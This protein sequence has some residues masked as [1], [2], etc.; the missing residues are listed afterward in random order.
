MALMLR[1]SLCRTLTTKFQGKLYRYLILRT[2][3]LYLDRDIC[4]LQSG[5]QRSSQC[6]KKE[7]HLYSL[8][9]YPHPSASM[10]LQAYFGGRFHKDFEIELEFQ[11][12]CD[13]QIS[14]ACPLA[15]MQLKCLETG[16]KMKTSK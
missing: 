7:K 12:Y 16:H 13:M 10:Q 1:D 9:V 5:H 8:L 6:F 15:A 2:P 3:L 14:P 4:K 11:V